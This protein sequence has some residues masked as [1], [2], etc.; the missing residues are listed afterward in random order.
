M[1]RDEAFLLQITTI[2]TLPFNQLH[3]RSWRKTEL[4]ALFSLS[5][6]MKADFFFLKDVEQASIFSPLKNLTLIS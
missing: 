6:N 3:H 1:Q 5:Q 2:I 4:S